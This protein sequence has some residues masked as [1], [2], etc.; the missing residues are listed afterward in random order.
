MAVAQ[1]I[2]AKYAIPH[3]QDK[4]RPTLRVNSAI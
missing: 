2:T 4:N 1:S 3:C